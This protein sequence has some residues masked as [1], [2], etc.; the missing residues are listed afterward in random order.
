MQDGGREV[1]P[2]RK[3]E[4]RVSGSTRL[5]MA[6]L[7]GS[8]RRWGLSTLFRCIGGGELLCINTNS[9]LRSTGATISIQFLL[10]NS[11]ILLQMNIDVYRSSPRE[12]WTGEEFLADSV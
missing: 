2:V 8:L 9:L 1:L 4:E 6:W 5:W 7:Q 10:V 3:L 12:F 11:G